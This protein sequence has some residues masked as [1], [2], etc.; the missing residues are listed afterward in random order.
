MTGCARF[1]IFF[2]I[3]AP[4]V[5]F[6]VTY[7]QGENPMDP[8]K[9]AIPESW[10]KNDSKGTVSEDAIM[11]GKVKAMDTRIESLEQEVKDLKQIISARDAEIRRLKN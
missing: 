4:A 6:G 5:Y 9:N 2:A 11:D 8:I 1:L 3:F 7:F 10:G